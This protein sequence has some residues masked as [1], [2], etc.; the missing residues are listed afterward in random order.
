[1]TAQP[2]EAARPHDPSED[3]AR[4]LRRAPAVAPRAVRA[5]YDEAL[6]AADDL[7]RFKQVQT[8]LRQWRL[9]AIAYTRSGYEEAIQDAFQGREDAFARYKPPERKGRV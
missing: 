2:A 6:D 4:D 9:R 8:L 5:E 1:M 3:P 7:V